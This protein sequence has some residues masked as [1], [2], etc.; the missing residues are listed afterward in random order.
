VRVFGGR[1][2]Y[3]YNVRKNPQWGGVVL[4]II[5]CRGCAPQS[6]PQYEGISE[7]SVQGTYIRVSLRMTQ[8]RLEPVSFPLGLDLF[9]PHFGGS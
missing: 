2:V 3:L 1:G 4:R 7:V 6:E 9:P 5:D 8:M